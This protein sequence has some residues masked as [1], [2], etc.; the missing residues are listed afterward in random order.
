MKKLKQLLY[1]SV[2]I[3]VQSN[4]QDPNF[5]QFFSSPL[6]IN[7]ALTGNINADWRA[8]ANFRD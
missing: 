4:A 7:P 5:S 2:M 1:V 6:N 8:I 3:A